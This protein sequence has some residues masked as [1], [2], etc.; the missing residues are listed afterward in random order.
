MKNLNL[1]ALCLLCFNIGVAKSEEQFVGP[2][3]SGVYGCKGQNNKV[4]EYEVVAR[5]K[6]NKVISHGDFGVY[7]FNTETENAL[8]YKGQGVASGYKLALTFNLSDGQNAEYSTGIAD[9]Q[10]VSNSRWAFTNHYYELDD[11][12]G[13]YGSEYC[14]MKKVVK[15]TKLSKKIK[16]S[17][18]A[19]PAVG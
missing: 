6:L 14:V 10:K 3:F 19:T 4:G 8:I 13:D 16:K 2:D 12:G 18:I 11:N 5:L 7:D 15:V 9:L 1:I 17:S